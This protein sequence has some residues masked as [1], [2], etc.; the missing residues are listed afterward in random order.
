MIERGQRRG[1]AFLAAAVAI[2]V[3]A[4][5][6]SPLPSSTR[7]ESASPSTASTPGSSAPAL[8]R[9]PASPSP[10]II[11]VPSPSTI[12]PPQSTS[13]RAALPVCPAE[14]DRFPIG[15][16][17]YH[18]YA[19]LCRALVAATKGHPEIARLFAIGRSWQ[20]RAIWAM[21][22]STHL[23]DGTHPPGVL[24]DGLHH[25]LEHLSLEMTLGIMGWLVD[26]YGHDAA[27]TRLVAT[28]AIFI[29]FDVNPDGA[30]ADI[31][32]GRF[33]TWRKNRQPGPGGVVGTDLNRNYNDHWG[34]C[35]LVSA[36]PASPYY[37]GPAPFSAPETRAVRDF[38]RS[39]V[40]NGRQQI[41]VAITFH[42]SGRLILW[43]Y[44]YTAAAVPSDMRPDDHAVFVAMGRAMARTDGYR[45]EQASGLYIDSGT[46]RDWYYG[47]QRIFAY[48]FELG[49]G[50]YQ[51]S[52]AIAPEVARNR[53]AVLYLIG[54]ADC[55]YRA[56]GKAAQHCG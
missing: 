8:V 26:G 18:T 52:S 1:P 33:H 51:P 10:D 46:A 2:L 13:S 31:A 16:T 37:R 36:R 11:P 5:C 27:I 50:T 44:G 43:P 34:C 19:A 29:I 4:G 12:T 53:G 39:R 55:P 56:I 24:F 35:G 14:S 6:G 28:R 23:T 38:V 30:A 48:T 21:E 15:Y 45:P 54:M 49:S 47:T 17:A 9:G 41:R 25:G 42:S 22:I 20:G 7:P 32:G 40:F 3:V